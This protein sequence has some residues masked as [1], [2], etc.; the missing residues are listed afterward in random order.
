MFKDMP[1]TCNKSAIAKPLSA[2]TESP[3]S[4]LFIRPVSMKSSLS[5]IEPPY[6]FEIKHITPEGVIPLQY[7]DFCKKRIARSLYIYFG[8]INDHTCSQIV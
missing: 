2:I 1:W 4:N 6:S 7:C 5:E 8:G 3:T